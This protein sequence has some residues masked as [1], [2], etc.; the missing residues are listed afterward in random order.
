MKN[1]TYAKEKLSTF[2]TAATGVPLIVIL[3]NGVLWSVSLP[4]QS[5]ARTD[6]WPYYPE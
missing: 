5:I 4:Y 3:V 2:C 6:A 1:K